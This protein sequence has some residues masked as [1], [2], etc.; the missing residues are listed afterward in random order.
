MD[1]EIIA[2]LGPASQA[3]EILRAMPH[4]GVT[5][6]RLNTSH[7]SEED[8]DRWCERL[9]AS[10]VAPFPLSLILDLQ[11]SKWR[12]GQF[13][14]FALREGRTVDLVCEIETLSEN[15]L[16]VPHG[17]FFDAAAASNGEIVLNDAKSRLQVVAVGSDR[18]RALITRG[19][20]ISSNKGVTLPRSE[21]RKES[22]S[23]KD[24]RIYQHTRQW[25]RVRYAI[26]YVKDAEEMGNYRKLLGPSTHLI[27]KLERKT[28]LDGA[29]RIARS[30]D[31]LWLCRGDLGAEMGPRPLAEAV[32][33]FADRLPAFSVPVLLAGQ[34]LEHM[35]EHACATRSE[36]CYLHDALKNGFGGIVLSDETAIGE[37]PLE[38]C[39]T[40]ALFR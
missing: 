12:L 23:E 20:E 1:Y 2:T 26:S 32:Y 25:P 6:F 36:L 13:P 38:S 7:L 4:A 28:S 27:A 16:P 34:V 9:T 3:E 8:V 24:E 31:E 40:A 11:G 30:A 15:V 10:T 21:Y 35:T 14:T 5:G 29:E 33:L 22:L 19:G 17:D 37:N 18:I 39:R